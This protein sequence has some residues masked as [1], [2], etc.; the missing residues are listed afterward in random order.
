MATLIHVD[1]HRE[2]RFWAISIPAVDSVTQA[3]RQSEIR[4]IAQDCAALI[5]GLPSHRVRIGAVRLEAQ[6][7]FDGE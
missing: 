1:V 3:Y 6:R 4:P 2:G 5:P 7:D